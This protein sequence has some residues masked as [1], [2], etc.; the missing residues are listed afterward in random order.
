M[1]RQRIYR[2]ASIV[3]IIAMVINVFLVIYTKAICP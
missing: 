2:V 3:N 1:M